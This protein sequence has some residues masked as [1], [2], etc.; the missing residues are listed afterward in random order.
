MKVLLAPHRHICCIRISIRLVLYV[1]AYWSVGAILKD[2][3][4]H[5]E[6]VILLTLSRQR[7]GLKGSVKQGSAMI[8]SVILLNLSGHA[9]TNFA[10]Y[11][12]T[13][14]VGTVG[15]TLLEREKM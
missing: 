11:I 2:T 1:F 4:F 13:F 12:Q 9:M 5:T 7:M 6:S 8:K 15:C 14:P 10:S 3:S